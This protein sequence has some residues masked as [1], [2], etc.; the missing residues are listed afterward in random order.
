M[1]TKLC[2]EQNLGTN[3]EVIKN[4][5]FVIDELKSY[6]KQEKGKTSCG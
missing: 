5:K 2:F 3:K 1:M 6:G 4:Y